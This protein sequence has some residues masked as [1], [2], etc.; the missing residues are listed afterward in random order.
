FHAPKFAG[1][2]NLLKTNTLHAKKR[3]K[4]S[5]FS[6][7]ILP[8]SIVFSSHLFA[9]QSLNI[10]G[11]KGLYVGNALV[12]QA[13]GDVNINAT[14]VMSFQNG[15]TP[16]FRLKGDFTNDAAGTYTHGTEKIRFNGSA[17]QNADFGGDEVYGIYTDNASNVQ[18][19]SNVNLVGDLQFD[20]GHILSSL[21]A[22]IT[23]DTDATVTNP[24]NTAHNNG[25]IAKNFNSTTDF[26]FPTGHGSSYNPI[27]FQPSGTSATTIKVQYNF[28]LTPDTNLKANDLYAVSPTEYWDITRESG[29][30]DGTVTLYW[31]EQSDMV[32]PDSSVVAYWDGSLWQNGGKQSFTGNSTTGTVLSNSISTFN[33][34]AIGR[35][36]SIIVLRITQ[37]NVNKLNEKCAGIKWTATD[38]NEL[39]HYSIEKSYDGL[40]YNEIE[41][42]QP[43]NKSQYQYEDC[44]E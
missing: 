9:Q 21:G 11:N 16:D 22:F 28:A 12:V 27:R 23:L 39:L 13:M 20:A 44:N 24:S 33:K 10:T 25:P 34:V 18:V 35:T 43:Q 6:S 32:F 8:L 31:D 37:F 1:G 5:I 7:F 4:T 19:A 40:S 36:S 26:S 3:C 29:T 38:E 41:K 17:L 15:G 30:E 2:G 14:G 42:V